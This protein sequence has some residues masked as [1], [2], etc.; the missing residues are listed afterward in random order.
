MI[1][2]DFPPDDR[3]AL[4]LTSPDARW[5]LCLQ[6]EDEIRW[7]PPYYTLWISDAHAPETVWWGPGR[8]IYFGQH[9]AFAPDSR[10]L[11]AERWHSLVLPDVEYSV[12]DLG[13]GEMGTLSR[14]GRALPT[15][16]AVTAP[17]G[18]GATSTCTVTLLGGAVLSLPIDPT[19][20]TMT[21]VEDWPF[22][23][24]DGRS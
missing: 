6:Y 24:R 9:C 18:E 11:V 16:L 5:R 10:H 23:R 13:S 3:Q 19:A 22:P 17:E 1:F 21:P 14:S 20:G 7:G 12:I 4:R 8:L 2:R 15:A